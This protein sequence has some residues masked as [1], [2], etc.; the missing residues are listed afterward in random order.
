MDPSA[1]GTETVFHYSIP[2]IQATG[3]GAEERAAEIG[4]FKSVVRG[5]ELLVS[6]LNPRKETVLLAESHHIP[7]VCSSEFVCLAPRGCEV[8]F[9]YYLYRS[10]PVREQLASTVESVTRSHQRAR[11]ESIEKL[12][13]PWPPLEEQRAIVRFLDE[14]VAKIEAL[15]G[16]K[17]RLIELER[18]LSDRTVTQ[19][20]LAGPAGGSTMK[21]S[22]VEWIRDIPA[23]WEVRRLGTLF[24][25]RD[26]RGDAD[27][28]ML[29]VSL[30]TGVSRRDFAE[31]RIERVAADLSNQKIA[32]AD[33]LVFNK[34][35]MWQG[36]VGVAPE[37]GL[38]STD[39]T[40]AVADASVEPRYVA[41][42][43]RTERALI[44]IDK[45]SHG[46]VRD[47]NRLYWDG[48]K[49]IQIPLPPLAEQQIILKRVEEAQG[50][51]TQLST[52]LQL[53]VARLHEYRTALITAAVSGELDAR[54]AA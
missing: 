30:N 1:L 51:M 44:E 38:V 53:A 24:R 42:L 37:D 15:V 35:R 22:R 23:N 16:E 50:Q 18:S 52:L 17:T 12:L 45:W 41:L 2:A 48:F 46:M 36:A 21:R 39:Y 8:R 7:T 29:R 54:E 40:V 25:E 27:L 4:S 43:L 47:R 10:I 3:D 20:L 31:D 32:R 26:E 11:P 33:D 34:M 9:A 6:R 28:P 49:N 5:G 13:L 14:Q 19:I